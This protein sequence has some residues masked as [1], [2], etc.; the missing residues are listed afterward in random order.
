MDT[1]GPQTMSKSAMGQISPQG[2]TL[3]DDTADRLLAHNEERISLIDIRAKNH[4]LLI[5]RISR[6]EA[7]T[8]LS[9]GFYLVINCSA[10][11]KGQGLEQY[12]TCPTQSSL[13]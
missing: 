5:P 6:Q 2:M 11:F 13:Y 7:S 10:G 9:P 12:N 1:E 4:C 8:R 3:K